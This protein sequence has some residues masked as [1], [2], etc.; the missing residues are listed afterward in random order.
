[1]KI[2]DFPLQNR[3]GKWL[4]SWN[5]IA[6]ILLLTF[7]FQASGET[8]K[9]LSGPNAAPDMAERWG[10]EVVA[11]R[12]AAA[13]NMLDFRYKVLDSD[14]AAALFMREKKPYLIHL[15]SGHVLSVPVTPKIGPLRSSNKPQK[16]RTYWMFFGNKS[17]L[18][19]KGDKV[20]VV[21]GAFKVENVMVQ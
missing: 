2:R 11:I 18:V 17:K 10:I 14:K 13:G 3:P 6:T 7:A 12:M 5:V 15:A 21:I 20:T 4:L 8:T 16:G 9:S 19:Q 1:M